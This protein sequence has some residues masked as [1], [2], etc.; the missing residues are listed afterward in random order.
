[1]AIHTVVAFYIYCVAVYTPT[2]SHQQG[3]RVVAVTSSLVLYFMHIASRLMDS[4]HDG[5]HLRGDIQK[6]ASAYSV[7]SDSKV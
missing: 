4:L 3:T 7:V 6:S 2:Q 1:M 5:M